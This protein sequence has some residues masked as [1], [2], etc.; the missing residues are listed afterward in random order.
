MTRRALS[1]SSLSMLGLTGLLAVVGVAIAL[2]PDPAVRGAFAGAPAFDA[3]GHR[4]ARGLYPENTW[5]AFQAALAIGVTTLE[6]DAGLTEDGF[7]VVHHDRKLDPAR[8]RGAGGQWVGEPAPAL[9]ELWFADLAPYDVG[10]ARPGGKVAKR[11]PAQVPIDGVPIPLL[12]EVLAR[13]EIASNR[14]MRYNVEVKTSPLAPGETAPPDIFADYLIET[15][16]LAGV[17]ERTTIQ[18]FD[19]RALRYAQKVAPEIATVY[20]TAEQ[21]WLNN[22]ERGQP[23]TSPW[24]AGIDIDEHD[25]SIARA[26]QAAGGAVWSPYFRDLQPADLAEARRLGLRVVVWTV[27]DPADMAAL[28]DQGVSGIITDYPD[29]LRL[30]MAD[31]GLALPPQFGAAPKAAD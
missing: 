8:T 23:G 15:L 9:A 20:L 19:W 7:V 1:R 21:S 29:R 5:P 25:G 24:T 3:Q 16:R 28:I 14:T 22:L 12:A 13:A 31:K 18:S 2:G 27:N 10:R 11:F 4:G 6:M 30:V 17:T 26:I